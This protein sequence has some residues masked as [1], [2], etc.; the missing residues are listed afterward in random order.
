MIKVFC[1]ISFLVLFFSCKES[2]DILRMQN[3]ENVNQNN[4]LE[5]WYKHNTGKKSLKNF[6]DLYKTFTGNDIVEDGLRKYNES[7]KLSEL[8]EVDQKFIYEFLE[9]FL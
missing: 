2:G 7:T 1:K 8:T 5:N 3:T 6:T 9:C 4:G